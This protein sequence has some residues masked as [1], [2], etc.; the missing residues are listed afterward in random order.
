MTLR[1]TLVHAWLALAL[2]GCGDDDSA[3]TDVPAEGGADADADVP[4]EAEAEAGADA[5]ADV[6]AEAE[7]EADADVPVGPLACS[8]G[9]RNGDETGVDCGGSCPNPDCCTNGYADIHLDETGVDCGGTCGACGPET[10][11]FV[12]DAGDDDNPGTSPAEPWRTID[13]VHRA[14]LQPGDAVLFRRGDTWRETLTIGASG[15]PEAWLTF[16]TYDAGPRPRI[17][18][19]T[20]AAD[21]TAVAGH[22][23]VWRSATT[24]ERPFAGKAASIFFG[25][26]DG[27]TRWG[28]VRA[29]DEVP[30][31]D[32]GFSF[33]L[34]EYD[35]C[36]A[37]GAV[38][39]FAPNDPDERYA[40]VE[41][42][43]RRA[44]VAMAS[45]A[46][47]QYVALDGLELM[48]TTM[49]GYDDGWPMDYE[50]RG[51][52]IQNCHVGYVGIQGGSSAMGL[53]VWHSDLVVR[54]NEIHDSGRRNISYN[55]Y[56]DNGRSHPGLTF[57]NVLFERNELYHGFHTTGLDISCA[58]GTAGETL[59]DTLR[60]FTIRDNLVWDDPADDP[61][62]APNDFTSMGIYL[63]GESASFTGFLVYNNVLR[64][65]KQKGLILYG[66][67][68]TRVFH[69]TFFGMNERAGVLGTS[70]GYRGMV[71]VA[72][73]VSNL[74]FD[75]NLLHGNVGP[76]QFHLQLV[77]FSGTSEDG[78]V[79]LDHNLYWQD[80]AD[81]ALVNTSAGAY[82]AAEWEAYRSA[83][84]WDAHSPAPQPPQL[85]DP[86]GF[87]F[88]PAAGSPAIDA[89]ATFAERTTDFL[90][91]GLVGVPDIGAVEFR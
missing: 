29:T 79:S 37:D 72:G 88:R 80:H 57:E 78:I 27:T 38:H 28:R 8:D 6:P 90:G 68:D 34:Q 75:G 9:E 36:W 33:L 15:T 61:Q 76:E 58:P 14:S 85:V 11:Y 25:G 52:R 43:Q 39:V 10:T 59:G 2:L 20:R 69:N 26:T 56:L 48:Y 84:G 21:W 91:E 3:G 60:N 23:Q 63:W 24:V 49:A 66:V 30:E 81:Q 73:D 51:L 55:I 4:A 13:R 86:P 41:V 31:C 35:W 70:T 89:G 62:A 18:G 54:N 22:P 32:G 16:G 46:P 44:A 12:A 7:A 45:H 53:Q 1:T 77:T 87:D 42:P 83:T 19:S 17:L 47:M 82:D 64:Y 5:D 65:T 50:V 74:S 40:F 71:T 67:H